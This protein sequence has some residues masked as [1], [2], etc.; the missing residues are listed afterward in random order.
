MNICIQTSIL[1]FFPRNPHIFAW[2]YQIYNDNK[3]HV[4]VLYFANYQQNLCS[5]LIASNPPH[6]NQNMSILLQNNQILLIFQS[7]N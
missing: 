4:Q 1:D 2:N 7:R 6:S 3:Y 5:I